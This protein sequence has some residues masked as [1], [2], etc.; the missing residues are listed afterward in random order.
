MTMGSNEGLK[1]YSQ[2]WRDLV[3]RVQPPLSDRELLD[4]FM[5]TLTGPFF[6][7]IIGSSSS[8]FT[9]LILTREQVESGIKSE[10]LPV[11]ASSSAVKK[12][13]S[14]KKDTNAV[15]G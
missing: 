8:G 12:I 13:F 7:H 5:G 14:G 15:Y 6:N 2:K 4:M 3:G 9:E 10:K 11:V 1:E